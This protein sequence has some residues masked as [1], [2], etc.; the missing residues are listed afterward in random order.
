MTDLQVKRKDLVLA[1]HGRSFW[2]LDDLSPLYELEEGKAK[3][4]VLFTPRDMVHPTQMVYFSLPLAAADDLYTL[5]WY[6]DGKLVYTLSDTVKNLSADEWGLYGVTWDLRYH[7]P[8]G[9]KEFRGPRVAPGSYKVELELGKV[10]MEK[11]FSILINPNLAFTGTNES[12]LVEQESVA[13][14]TARLLL[15][16]NAEIREIGEAIEEEKSQRKKDKLIQRLTLLEKGPAPYDPPAL[17]D[18]VQYLYRMVSGTPQKLGA[19]AMSRLGSLQEE[20]DS[21]KRKQGI[22]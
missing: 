18:Q 16:I 9:E 19:D 6:R 3:E 14:E 5:T 1:T 20:W 15:E 17:K 13:L 22:M 7:L 21:Y 8:D 12:D 10:R 11:P 4:T 2:I